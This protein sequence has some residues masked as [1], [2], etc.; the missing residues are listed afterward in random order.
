[1]GNKEYRVRDGF[2]FYLGSA[3]YSGGDVLS[4]SD[5]QIKGQAQKVEDFEDYKKIQMKKRASKSS[6]TVEEK[7][8][9]KVEE[10]VEEKNNTPKKKGRRSRTTKAGK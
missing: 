5:E 4:L 3:H 7:I 8:E 2:T 1:M 9:E 6:K 10:K